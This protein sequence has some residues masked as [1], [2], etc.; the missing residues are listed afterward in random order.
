MLGH[1]DILLL[2]IATMIAVGS[3]MKLMRKR[4]DRLVGEVQ[5]QLEAQREAQARQQAAAKKAAKKKQG[6]A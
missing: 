2:A 5:K 3:L 1:W 4:R 6:A